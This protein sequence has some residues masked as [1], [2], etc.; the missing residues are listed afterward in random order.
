MTDQ[1]RISL[2]DDAPDARERT[3]ILIAE[4]RAEE[5]LNIVRRAVAGDA[6][7]RRDAADLL[8]SVADLELPEPVSEALWQL[9]QLKRQAEVMA[10]IAEQSWDDCSG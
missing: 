6:H 3:M 1:K 2:L 4:R 8:V 7:W 10:D 9:D 5:F